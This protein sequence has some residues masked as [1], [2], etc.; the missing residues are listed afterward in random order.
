MTLFILSILPGYLLHSAFASWQIQE[1]ADER[2]VPRW[3]DKLTTTIRKLPRCFWLAFAGTLCLSLPIGYFFAVSLQWF[4]F[5]GYVVVRDLMGIDLFHIVLGL[6]FGV[7][8]SQQS[9]KHLDESQPVY[10]EVG[11]PGRNQNHAANEE[12]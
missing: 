4:G 5:T 10:N 1:G 11:A 12:P 3:V 6:F 2:S 8:L 7:I 9:R